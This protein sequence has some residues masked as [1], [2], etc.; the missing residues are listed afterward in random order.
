MM[1]V[2]A[3]ETCWA[4]NKRQVIN[5]WNFCIWLVN[6]FELSHINNWTETDLCDLVAAKSDE[7]ILIDKIKNLTSGRMSEWKKGEEKLEGDW[8]VRNTVLK[9]TGKTFIYLTMTVQV[10]SGK[11]RSNFF[12]KTGGLMLLR[13][14]T[15]AYCDNSTKHK[16][17]VYSTCW[18]TQ[19]F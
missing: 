12:K 10:F 9:G 19:K 17:P 1:G 16:Y 5:L 2:E 3:P 7:R 4:T 13:A 11:R 15:A 18:L 14:I 6:L 8:V